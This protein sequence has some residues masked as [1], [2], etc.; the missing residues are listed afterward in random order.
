M[1][2]TKLLSI[3]Q[4]II[5]FWSLLKFGDIFIIIILNLNTF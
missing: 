2:E 4:K 5:E 3:K 1:K